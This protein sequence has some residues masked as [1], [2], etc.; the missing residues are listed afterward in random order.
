MITG[1][2]NLFFPPPPS[3]SKVRIGSNLIQKKCGKS[4][5]SYTTFPRIVWIGS[6][7]SPYPG[8]S[9]FHCFTVLSSPT[10]K[11]WKKDVWFNKNTLFYLT[12]CLCNLVQET[13]KTRMDYQTYKNKA[14]S[15][16]T[17]HFYTYKKVGFTCHNI[18]L[19]TDKVHMHGLAGK[20]LTFFTIVHM[21]PGFG[22][23]LRTV[24]TEPMFWLLLNSACTIII[25]DTPIS[26]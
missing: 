4:I 22:F 8:L 3:R 26:K 21:V 17:I 5:L 20:K 1:D 9:I 19:R 11:E 15:L 2:I 16:F 18:S 7:S 13:L 24:L 14:L 10:W 6:S 25:L 12:R 23:V